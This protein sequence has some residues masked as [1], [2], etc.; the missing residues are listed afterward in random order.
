MMKHKMNIVQT[1]KH[2]YYT[3]YIAP[4][5]TELCLCVLNVG[6]RPGKQDLYAL[7]TM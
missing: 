3:Q 5:D 4:H 7:H 2:H 1:Y 6:Q